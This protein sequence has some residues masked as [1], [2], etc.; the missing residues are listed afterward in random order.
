MKSL[1]SI[2]RS[3]TNGRAEKLWSNLENSDGFLKVEYDNSERSETIKK[4]LKNGI[5][6]IGGLIITL[7]T[8]QN[9]IA[10][11]KPDV[12]TIKVIRSQVFSDE[13]VVKA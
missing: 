10:Y 1:K 11:V 2:T 6:M 12:N 9:L 7:D 13:S 3:R 4:Q 8:T 5:K